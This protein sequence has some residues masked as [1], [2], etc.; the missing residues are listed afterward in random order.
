MLVFTGGKMPWEKA[1]KTE[2]EVLNV[3]AISNGIS[4]EKLFETKIINHIV[5]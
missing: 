1:K 3:Y 5:V 4:S 2:G